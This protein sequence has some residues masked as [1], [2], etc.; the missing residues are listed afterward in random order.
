MADLTRDDLAEAL[1]AIRDDADAKGDLRVEL[2]TLNGNIE[3][4][5]AEFR[6]RFETLAADQLGQKQDQRTLETRVTTVERWQW[7]VAGGL[8]LL[9]IALG[10]VGSTAL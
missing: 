6:V 2:A 5:T 4:L 1:Y 10:A 3:T 9:G 8:G 7:K